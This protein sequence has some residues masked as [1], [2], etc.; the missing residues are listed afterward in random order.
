MICLIY[1]KVVIVICFLLSQVEVIVSSTDGDRYLEVDLPWCT[2]NS[3]I[4]GTW[5]P[6]EPKYKSFVCCGG[7]YAGPYGQGPPYD[8]EKVPGYCLPKNTLP[9]FKEFGYLEFGAQCGDDCCICDRTDDT[10]FVT[11][12]REKYYWKPSNCNILEWNSTLFCELLGERKILMMGD[13]SMQQTAAT[14]M[15]MITGGNGTCAPQITFGRSDHVIFG[16][17]GHQNYA[18]LVDEIEPNITIVTAGAHIEDRGDVDTILHG[19]NLHQQT[20]ASLGKTV[21]TVVWKTQNPGHLA[22]H[23]Y[24]SPVAEFAVNKSVPDHY[25]WTEFTKFDK[26]TDIQCPKYGF[27]IL[28]MSPLYL[29]P[30]AHIEGHKEDCLHYC[31]PGPLDLFSIILQQMLFNN[32]I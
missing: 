13:S 20:R 22:C 15:S 24:K 14:L 12:R 18:N 5:I 31:M 2:N 29:R 16:F 30:D 10:R 9:S 21:P 4:E 11:N 28:H 6:Y 25:R 3:H 26:H 27:K 1:I 17:K 23:K 7:G 19:I 8:F 32:E